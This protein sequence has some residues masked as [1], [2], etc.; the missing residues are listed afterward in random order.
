MYRIPM[1]QR[2][3]TA[4]GVVAAIAVGAGG[5]HVADADEPTC[6]VS[7]VDY[8][9]VGSLLLRDTQFGAANGTYPLGA[10][11]IRLRF[12]A[13]EGGGPHE[14]RL[15]SYELDNHLTVNASFALWSTK[16][17]TDS[18]TRVANDCDG[19]AKG[20][21][22]NGDVV[23]S[24][25]VDGYQSDGTLNCEGNV[26]GKFGAPPTGSSALHEPPESV[27]FKPFH[28]NPDGHTFTMDYAKVS[29]SDSPKR[30]AYLALSGRE[31]HRTCVTTV[32][33]CE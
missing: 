18:H 17:V 8:S 2:F 1:V 16:V 3:V 7:D 9:V 22:S 15:M 13:P 23:W 28:F 33:S 11:K 29:H 19:A 30:T 31:T 21:V 24:T 6:S 14:A 12:K 20:T 5:T 26:C 4:A 32:T 25:K 27:S 10:G